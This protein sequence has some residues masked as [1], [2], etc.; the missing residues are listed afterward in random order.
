[1]NSFNRRSLAVIF[2]TGLLIVIVNLTWWLFYA[3]TENSFEEQLS[4]RL[5]S[6]VSLGASG[7][8]AETVSTLADGYLSGY[9]K[10]LDKLEQIKAVDSLSEVFILDTEYNY[11]ATTSFDE[12]S[13]YYLVSLNR[14]AIDSIFF[15]RGNEY[16]P[17]VSASYQT[18]DFILKSA[19][20]P[21]FDSTGEVRAVL[22]IEADV[23]YTDDLLS[24]RRSLYISTAVSVGFGL[25]FGILFFMVQRKISLA[26]RSIML[27]QSQA[28]LGRMVAVV[29]HEVKNPLMI[30]RASA[31]SLKKSSNKPEAD[32]IIEEID[33]LNQIVSGYL[34]FAS[35][36]LI[37]KTELI[38]VYKLVSEI[39]T[40]FAPRLNEKN[41]LLKFESKKEIEDINKNKILADPIALRQ[42]IINLILNASDT[43]AD[44]TNPEIKLDIKN[45]TDQTQI[46]V[47]DNGPG[48]DKKIIKNIFEPFYTTKT[49]GSGLGL[50]HTRKLMEAMGGTINVEID[51]KKQTTFVLSLLSVDKEK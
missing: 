31:E 50:F 4:R 32:F 49:T 36:K 22:G 3:Q 10:A 38:E 40:Q 35:G 27:S 24:L 8:D 28:N 18:D 5:T 19:F 39:V 14:D 25:L 23:D 11:L 12:D 26:E 42:V 2:F 44:S 9:D 16:Y 47:T 33:R 46:F 48:I 45:R 15:N 6:L 7:L 13:I 21:L 17:S 1:M 20:A 30:M 37:L 43:L 41:I 51:D 34:G 29:S